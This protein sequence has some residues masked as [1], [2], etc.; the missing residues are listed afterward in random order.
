MRSMLSLLTSA[1]LGAL[2]VF[3]HFSVCIKH[4]DNY[5]A[6]QPRTAG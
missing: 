5:W 3:L 6:G 2:V 4:A 1:Q